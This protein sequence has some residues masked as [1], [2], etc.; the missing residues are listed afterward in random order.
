MNNL[1]WKLAKYLK[2]LRIELEDLETDLAVM[3]DLYDLREQ[4]EEITDYVFLENVALLKS[5]I[6][7]VE[8][9]IRSIDDIPVERFQ[10]LD[11]FVDYIDS[12]F[13]ERTKHSGYP[14]SVYALVRRKLSKVSRYILS[15]ET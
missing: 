7:G 11:E 6:A 14:E 1:E 3:K 12:L 13:R 8:S 2:V 4:Q 10:H 5:E 9:L 15:T